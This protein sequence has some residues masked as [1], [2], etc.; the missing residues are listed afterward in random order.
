MRIVEERPIE[1]VALA[2]GTTA[3]QVEH[4]LRRMLESILHILIKLDAG[5]PRP[6][7]DSRT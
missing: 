5:D 4:H 3:A 2:L 1:E 7:A 6:V